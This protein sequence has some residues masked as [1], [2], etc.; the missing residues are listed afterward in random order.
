MSTERKDSLTLKWG[1][2][3]AWRFNDPKAVELLKE[4]GGLG[5]SLSAMT[6]HDTPR[7]KA[8]ICEL[9]DLGD[10]DTVYLDWDGVEVSK[11]KA[12]QYVM[13]YGKKKAT[14]G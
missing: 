11:D 5:S 12:K 9:I 7:Q 8:I 14:H 1:T 10:F 2:L 3:K 4:Y 13:D 6:Q